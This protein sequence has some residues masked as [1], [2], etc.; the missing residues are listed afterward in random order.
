MEKW[1]KTFS[2]EQIDE[3]SIELLE[4]GKDSNVFLFYGIVGA[5]KTTLIK[6]ICKNL[7]VIDACSSPSFA[8]INEYK[9]DAGLIYHLDLYRIKNTAELL[10]LGFYEYI[11]SGN[12]CFIEW[13][14]IAIPLLDQYYTLKIHINN[15]QSRTITLEKK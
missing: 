9:Y 13:P 12:Y 2:L 10:D 1:Q 11:D 6:N 8:I 5:G 14:E 15:D 7:G 3:A 4:K